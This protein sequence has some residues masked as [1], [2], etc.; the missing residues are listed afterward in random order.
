MV[1]LVERVDTPAPVV[2]ADVMQGNI[3]RMQSF[4][5]RHPLDMRPHI[6]THKCVE[7]GRRQV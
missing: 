1:A 3:D 5:A 4:A 2:L 6:K 7:I